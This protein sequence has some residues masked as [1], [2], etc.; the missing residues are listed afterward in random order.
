MNPFDMVVAVIL[1][2]CIIRGIFRGLIRELASIIGVVA[3]FFTAYYNY[4]NFSTTLAGWIPNTPYVDIISFVILFCAVLLIVTGLGMIIRL[5][6]KVVLLGMV[7]RILGAL[8]GAVKGTLIVSILFIF[9]VSFLPPGGAEVVS[10][11]KLWP[12]VNTLS[13][14][15]IRVIP[16]EMHTGFLKN[17]DALKKEWDKK[18]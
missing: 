5:I 6:M 13:K 2:Y 16:E 17:I 11:S 15:I 10:K 7:D 12:Y 1:G 8:F 3:G 9:L 18:S 4:R 14:G